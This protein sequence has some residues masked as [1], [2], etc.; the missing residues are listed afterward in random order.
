M[1]EL[2][3]FIQIILKQ[4]ILSNWFL[5]IIPRETIYVLKKHKLLALHA[6]TKATKKIRTNLCHCSSISLFTVQKRQN[7]AN[8]YL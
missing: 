2:N 4:T 1:F 6:V 8:H 7:K 5:Q 3:W